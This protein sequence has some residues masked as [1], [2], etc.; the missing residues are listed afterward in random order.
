MPAQEKFFVEI[1]RQFPRPVRLAQEGSSVA[2]GRR[3][4]DDRDKRTKPERNGH[5]EKRRG[6]ARPTESRRVGITEHDRCGPAQAALGTHWPRGVDGLDV[7]RP[8]GGWGENRLRGVAASNRD[9]RRAK[10][11]GACRLAGLSR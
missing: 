6:G 8:P 10:E 11:A 3:V 9:A 5:V 2:D 1:Q 7:A 4:L